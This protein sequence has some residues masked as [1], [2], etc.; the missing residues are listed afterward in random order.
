MAAGG[1]VAWTIHAC[2]EVPA[3]PLS[4]SL[5]SAKEST[6]RRRREVGEE[7][8]RGDPERVREPSDRRMKA[9]AHG[10]DGVPHRGDL[11]RKQIAVVTCRCPLV[12]LRHL[13]ARRSIRRHRD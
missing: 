3:S 7:I 8:R 13:H 6:Q 12:V 9:S 1:Y 4:R 11:G 2:R 10:F 5:I